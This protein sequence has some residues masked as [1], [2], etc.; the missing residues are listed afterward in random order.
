VTRSAF[1]P[2]AVLGLAPGSSPAEVRAAWKRLA[3]QFHPDR[4][5]TAPPAEQ[6]RAAAHMTAVNVAYD[7]IRSGRAAAVASTAF[8]TGAGYRSDPADGGSTAPADGGWLDDALLAEALR[9]AELR[10]QGR[11]RGRHLRLVLFLAGVVVLA[12]LLHLTLLRPYQYDIVI[13]GA[14]NRYTDVDCGN[15]YDRGSTAADALRAQA[16]GSAD[17]QALLHQAEVVEYVCSDWT[18]DVERLALPTLALGAGAVWIVF[19]RRR[20]R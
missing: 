17:R 13:D 19:F 18:A 8:G 11:R 3:L 4:F 15:G 20:V 6:Q 14:G 9:R 5:A 12:G 7:E 16:A 2:W 10:A 1:D